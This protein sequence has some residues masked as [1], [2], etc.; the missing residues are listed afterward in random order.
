MAGDPLHP[1][2]GGEQRRSTIGPYP[3]AA[4]DDVPRFSR[5]AG[6]RR[7]VGPEQQEGVVGGADGEC[8][9]DVP[10]RGQ[11]GEVRLRGEGGVEG[12]FDGAGAAGGGGQDVGEGG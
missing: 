10:R 8:E 4:E 9:E 6:V 5:G 11:G 1:V 3:R 2:V 12:E 7:G